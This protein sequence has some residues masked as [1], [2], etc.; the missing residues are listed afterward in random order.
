MQMGV[1]ISLFFSSIGSFILF[2][3]REGREKEARRQKVAKRLPREPKEGADKVARL[4]YAIE[5]L[6]ICGW[7]V[8]KFAYR[9]IGFL[10]NGGVLNM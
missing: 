4:R 2:Q 9:I 1:A 10:W 5:V 8:S 6:V 3:A 7:I